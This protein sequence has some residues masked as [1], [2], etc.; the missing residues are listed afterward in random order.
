LVVT[1]IHQ[2]FYL[3]SLF[4]GKLCVGAHKCSFDL[5]V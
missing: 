5:V 4:L 2:R 3:V 1:Y